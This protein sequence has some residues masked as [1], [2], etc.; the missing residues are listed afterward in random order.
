MFRRRSRRDLQAH[1]VEACYVAQT[2]IQDKYRDAVAR[3]ET[4]RRAM[5]TAVAAGRFDAAKA[6]LRSIR[7]GEQVQVR[8]QAQLFAVETQLQVLQETA[9]NHDVLRSM[10]RVNT[11]MRHLGRNVSVP[12]FE[13]HAASL[14]SHVDKVR[15]CTDEWVMGA[16]EW[17]EPFDDSITDEDVLAALR[18]GTMDGRGGGHGTVAVP[19]V[20]PVSSPPPTHATVAIQ[21]GD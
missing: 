11:A 16:D 6:A 7:H 8:Y 14:A 21:T 19:P 13:R 4:H 5:A 20:S 12:M 3:V 9:T 15:E 18:D 10:K 2:T 1:A 17:T